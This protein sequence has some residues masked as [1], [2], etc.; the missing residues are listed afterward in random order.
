MITK[1]M[2]KIYTN[3][4]YSNIKTTQYTHIEDDHNNHE[5]ELLNKKK[6][7]KKVIVCNKIKSPPNQ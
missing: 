3:N 1:S 5:L 7:S 2:S 4:Q 6:K